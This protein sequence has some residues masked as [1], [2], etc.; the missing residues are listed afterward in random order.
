[1]RLIS[2]WLMAKSPQIFIYKRFIKSGL[3]KRIALA[4]S[5]LERRLRGVF[6][7]LIIFNFSSCKFFNE[8]N[9]TQIAT[10]TTATI[11]KPEFS[12]DSA[13]RFIEQQLAFGARVPGTSAQQKCAAYFEQKL[14]S[15]GASVIMQRTNVVV[16]TGKSVPCINVIA[17]YNPEV[18][19]RLMICTHWDA[20]PFADRDDS[21]VAKPILAADDGA[22]GSAVLLEL[23]RQLQKKNPQIGIDLI[24][25]DVEDYGQPE[26]E[27]DQKQGDFYCL[28]TQYWC[29]NP[30]VP[31]YTAE[32][33]ILLDMVGA[34]GATFTYEG[35][36]MQYAP[37]FMKR[38]WNI[39]AQLGYSNFFQ[40]ELTSQI[41]DDHYYINQ[42]TKIPTIDIINRT[43]TTKTGFAAHWHTHED[44]MDIIDKLTLQAVGETVLATIYDF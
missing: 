2:Q 12:S 3:R 29:K 43:Y 22:S 38:V 25:L 6:L 36:S 8:Q 30:H 14:K 4:V 1:M 15:Y 19:R 9:D 11:S 37:D 21:A 31:N 24:F 32:N 17:S 20:R 33:G 40:K 41:I 39:A 16:Y 13:Y 34:K 10:T 27:L 28:G 7:I 18:K 26:Y 5:P 42:L 44:D 35:I 23:A